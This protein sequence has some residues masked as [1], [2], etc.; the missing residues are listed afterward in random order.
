VLETAEPQDPNLV[1]AEPASPRWQSPRAAFIS[2]LIPGLGQLITGMKRKAALL[3]ALDAI[4][5]GLFFPPLRLPDSYRGWLGLVLFEILVAI[6]ASCDALRSKTASRQAGSYLWLLVVLPVA[7]IVPLATQAM[8]LPISGF[9]DYKI[10]SGSMAP[11]VQ[12]G[13]LIMADMH[14]YRYR[15]PQDGEIILFRSPND[16]NVILI[17]RVIA[18]GGET[19]ASKDGTIWRNGSPIDEPYA[20]HP[21]DAPDELM[22]FGPITIPANRLFVMGD[23]RDISLDSRAPEFGPVADSAVLGKALYVISAANSRDGERLY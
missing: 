17:K 18:V 19:I 1:P 9:R 5:L 16:R 20:R 10:S 13:D 3:F 23:D 8:L 21:G 12:K 11:A 4:W 14:S 22:N 15:Q 6:S 2:A 7:F